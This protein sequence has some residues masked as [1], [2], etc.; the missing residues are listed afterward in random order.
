MPASIYRYSHSPCEHFARVGLEW[1]SARLA[2]DESDDSDIDPFW[3]WRRPVLLALAGEQPA[4]KKARRSKSD[5][6]ERDGIASLAG[7]KIG[8]HMALPELKVWA[9]QLTLQSIV[10]ARRAAIHDAIAV[11]DRD[12]PDPLDWRLPIGG[13]SGI[14]PR[15]CVTAL[16]A[17]FSPDALGMDIVTYCAAELLATLGMEISPITRFS[18]RVYGYQTPD[19][20]DWWQFG[21]ANRGGYYRQLT[22][23]TPHEIHPE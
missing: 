15:S 3:V 7:Q 16:D 1:L 13:A 21:I 17:G 5:E 12:P 2:P 19:S 9:G 22:M 20:G 6:G 10:D 11:I 14:D 8:W 18:H 23:S 4:K